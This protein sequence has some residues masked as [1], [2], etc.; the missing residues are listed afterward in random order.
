MAKTMQ[1]RFTVTKG[2]GYPL[3]FNKVTRVN[4]PITDRLP[5]PD[6]LADL[7][8]F[9]FI[10]SDLKCYRSAFLKLYKSFLKCKVKGPAKKEQ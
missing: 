9:F 2:R 10:L 4:R 5:M 7:C 6:T 1:G 3:V 8:Q